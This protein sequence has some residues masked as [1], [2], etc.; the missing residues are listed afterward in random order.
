MSKYQVFL[1]GMFMGAAVF[2]FA[3]YVRDCWKGRR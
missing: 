2:A 3:G 1:L